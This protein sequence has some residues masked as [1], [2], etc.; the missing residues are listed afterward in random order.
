M[1]RT[2]R[3]SSSAA[4]PTVRA[5]PPQRR[6]LSDI[7]GF[8]PALRIAAGVAVALV[9]IGGAVGAVMALERGALP[10]STIPLASL[11]VLAATAA[12]LAGRAEGKHESS[13]SAERSRAKGR[14]QKGGSAAANRAAASKS[15]STAMDAAGTDG[16]SPASPQAGSVALRTKFL[17][18]ISQALRAPI[19][20]ICL[21]ARIIR[22]HYD[23]T[24]EVVAHFGDTLLAE[25][26]RLGQTVD[27]FLELARLESGLV[28]WHEDE[29]D[30]ADLIQ[31][32][33]AEV[34]P[35]AVSYGV[36][37]AFTMEP[38]L[39]PLHVDRERVAQALT[40]LLAMAVRSA[41]E[42][43]EIV[44]QIAGAHGGWVFTVGGTSFV[45]PHAEARKVHVRTEGAP[46][47]EQPESRP[48]G[49]GLGLCLCREIV[50][51]YQGR[52]WIEGTPGTSGCAR[53]TI[54]YRQHR[55]A[56]VAATTSTE[57]A[58]STTVPSE[59]PK[60][61][62]GTEPG[63][64]AAATAAPVDLELR[65]E[66]A[67]KALQE[68][69]ASQPRVDAQAATLSDPA[70][71]STPQRADIESTTQVPDAQSSAA[72]VAGIATEPI[73]T[74][75]SATETGATD[76]GGPA[77]ERAATQRPGAKI[78]FGRRQIPAETSAS[79]R[80]APS[81]QDSQPRSVE[82]A[83]GSLSASDP[84]A[85]P[86]LVEREEHAVEVEVEVEVEDAPV[87]AP[88]SGTMIT[89][90]HR[91]A[92]P[93]VLANPGVPTLSGVQS[94][95]TAAMHGSDELLLEI[96]EAQS[97]DGHALIV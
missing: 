94:A 30:A 27:E 87:Q 96:A 84:A 13:T 71:A 34:E 59:R 86:R 21:A 29:V 35:V 3:A 62:S 92:G 88:V 82:P 16:T 97:P 25:A 55:R 41:N 36:S 72:N 17:D 9:I 46:V 12:Y 6:R 22:K 11:A 40:I 8:A 31:R 4:L 19:T 65:R 95:A 39:P 79:T 58:V 60:V 24:P 61:A 2:Q 67:V 45:Y 53:F 85:T 63:Y 83:P 50:A 70:E 81:R 89:A 91:T 42:G 26:D 28:E 56:T 76:A 32:A 64:G 77:D 74:T 73:A 7:P 33:V 10:S 37:V 5:L 66:L 15:A 90:T 52:F 80:P 75:P 78:S 20:S 23:S 51:R 54:P 44:I 38:G 69:A 18:D 47:V 57:A 1:K 14:L 49:L 48:D 43:S 68:R 93:P